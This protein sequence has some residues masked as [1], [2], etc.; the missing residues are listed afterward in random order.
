[1]SFHVHRIY[2][3]YDHVEGPISLCC[4]KI[5][6]L[7]MC[8]ARMILSN[9]TVLSW[10]RLVKN[11]RV[12]LYTIICTH[13]RCS[14]KIVDI[15]IL[16]HSSNGSTPIWY[17]RPVQRSVFVLTISITLF[18]NHKKRFKLKYNTHVTRCRAFDNNII[19]LEPSSERFNPIIIV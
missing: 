15:L 11:V 4:S 19:S 9:A 10:Q 18:L 7:P 1:M 2:L 13:A 14:T 17:T 16:F 12:S 5:L 8:T 3:I 6:C